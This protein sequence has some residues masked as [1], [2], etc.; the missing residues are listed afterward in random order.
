MSRSAIALTLLLVAMGCAVGGALWGQRMERQSQQAAHNAKVVEQLTNTLHAGADLARR[1][2]EASQAIRQATA[3]LQQAQAKNLKDFR[4]ELQS[5]DADRAGCVFPAG[6][7][8]GISAARDRSAAAA[9]N[10]IVD[11][12]PTAPGG[13]AHDR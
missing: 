5:T 6:V 4:H 3:N 7:M 2:T 9:A 11:T 12:M 1:S 8:R 13:P 10:G